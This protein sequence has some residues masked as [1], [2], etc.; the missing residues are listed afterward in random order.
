[1]GVLR[2]EKQLVRYEYDFAKD[3]GEIGAID[4]RAD[5]VGLKEGMIV[6]DI[7]VRAIEGLDGDATPTVQFGDGTTANAFLANSFA[8]LDTAGK[9]TRAA[10]LAVRLGANPKLTMTVGAEDLD[11]GKLEVYLEVISI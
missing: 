5:I 4:L 11:A 8:A 9:V 10:A 3:G 1:M 7:I 2:N 6:T